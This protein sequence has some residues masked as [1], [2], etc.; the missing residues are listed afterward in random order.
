M[1]SKKLEK[2]SSFT[3]VFK[4]VLKLGQPF[5][6]ETLLFPPSLPV[7]GKHIFYTHAFKSKSEFAR[8]LPQ[9]FFFPAFYEPRVFLFCLF[10]KYASV[11][12]ESLFLN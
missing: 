9:L 7:F 12:L 8:I 4:S 2:L 5:K 10:F 11:I 3:L 6:S 1:P